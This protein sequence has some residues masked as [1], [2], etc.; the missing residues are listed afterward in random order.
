MSKYRHKD[1]KIRELK[2]EI[3]MLKQSIDISLELYNDQKKE[4]VSYRRIIKYSTVLM[5]LLNL[6]S[7]SGDTD[8][9]RIFKQNIQEFY[10]AMTT[11]LMKLPT[12]NDETIDNEYEDETEGYDDGEGKDLWDEEDE[13]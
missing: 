6:I 12:D 7:D 2:Q 13:Y 9:G 11:D 10:R 5:L 8:I 1:K 4:R 3:E